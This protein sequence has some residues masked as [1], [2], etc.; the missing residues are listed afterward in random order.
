MR[1]GHF[2]NQMRPDKKLGL[3]VVQCPDA[4][5]VP[6]LFKRFWGV[7]AGADMG[8][9]STTKKPPEKIPEGAWL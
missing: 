8:F 2:V 4:V 1:A 3:T 7:W 6:D 5:R 9:L